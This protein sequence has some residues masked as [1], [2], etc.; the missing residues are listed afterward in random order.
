LLCHHVKDGYVLGNENAKKILDLNSLFI[1]N[2]FNI[3]S[4]KIINDYLSNFSSLSN[5]YKRFITTNK[6]VDINSFKIV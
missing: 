2:K 1:P 6:F 4:G 3:S 5:L